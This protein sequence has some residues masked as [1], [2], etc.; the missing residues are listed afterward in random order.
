MFLA[1]YG[2]IPVTK[3][4][5][6]KKGQGVGEGLTPGDLLFKGPEV[7]IEQGT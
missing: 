3:E 4:K 2:D 1:E 5:E 6:D 7:Q